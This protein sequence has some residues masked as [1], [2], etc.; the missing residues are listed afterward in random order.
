MTQLQN[1]S[2]S[3]HNGRLTVIALFSSLA[4][5]FSYVEMLIP[6][7]LGIPGVKLGIANLV[8]VIAIY[9]FKASTALTINIIRICLA[10]LLFTGLF[11]ALYS[12]CGGLI[13]FLSM[14]IVK[15]TDKF[16]MV[17]VS[18]T[19]GV[20]HNLGQLLAAA[21]IISDIHIFMYFPVLMFSGII[22]G[23][24]I[25]FICYYVNKKIPPS[26]LQVK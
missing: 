14:L 4:L 23:I 8:I 20:F 7:P 10:G 12:I 9:R 1:K 19:G 16:S 17:G 24:I 18:M 5:I 13:S 2:A 6:I 15:K 3:T 26:L 25:G 21:F 11:G 22:T